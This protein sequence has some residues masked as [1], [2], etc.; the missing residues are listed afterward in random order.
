[1]MWNEKSYGTNKMI[2]SL[3]SETRY[4]TITLGQFESHVAA[5]GKWL[6][7]GKLQV[8]VISIESPD[9]RTF[10]FKFTKKYVFVKAKVDSGLKDMV[11]FEL[12]FMGFKNV[13]FVKIVS[14]LADAVAKI[15][16]YPPFLMG[17]AKKNKI[18]EENKS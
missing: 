3:D 8:Q 10:V 12:F 17:K 14:F 16:L 2:I 4:S 18:S 7:S 9:I 15:I 6:P 1:M 13:P 11:R 5:Y